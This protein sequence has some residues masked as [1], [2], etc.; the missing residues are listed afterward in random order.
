MF[1]VEEL[2]ILKSKQERMDRERDEEDR[3]AQKAFK[4]K[5]V[6]MNKGQDIHKMKDNQVHLPILQDEGN[7][8]TGRPEAEDDDDQP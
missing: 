3:F 4:I 1:T 6:K 8:A 5:K 7:P 2:R